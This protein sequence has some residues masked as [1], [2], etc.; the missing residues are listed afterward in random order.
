MERGPIDHAPPASLVAV[1][2][3]KKAEE[4]TPPRIFASSAMDVL[5]CEL[6]IAVV[7]SLYKCGFALLRE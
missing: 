1:A 4:E 5:Q 2:V 3:V 6:W 7:S